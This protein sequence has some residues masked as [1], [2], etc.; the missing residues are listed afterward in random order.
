MGFVDRWLEECQDSLLEAVR[1]IAQVSVF[2][3]HPWHPLTT[4]LCDRF[5]WLLLEWP[6][7]ER[8]YPRNLK[9]IVVAADVGRG[10]PDEERTLRGLVEDHWEVSSIDERYRS[11]WSRDEIELLSAEG[12]LAGH[13]HCWL[14]LPPVRWPSLLHVE[15]FTNLCSESDSV[16]DARTS[17]ENTVELMRMVEAALW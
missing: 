2:Y 3:V 17:A 13:L 12:R 4:M 6:E 7:N 16:C 9:E 11:L 10:I 5:G 8:W 15:V 14:G 1:P